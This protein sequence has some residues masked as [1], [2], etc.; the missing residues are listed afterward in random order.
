MFPVERLPQEWNDRFEAYFGIVPPTDTLGVLQ[1]V[2]WSSGLI[3]YFSTYALG[4]ML[5]AQYWQKALQA[6]PEIPAEIE[7]GKFDTLLTWLNVNIHQHGRKFTSAE[8]T[9]RITGESIKSSE[10]MKYLEAKYGEIYGL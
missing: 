4:N 5:A 2:H 1:D 10:Y 3:G 8:L 9:Q 6:H 7:R